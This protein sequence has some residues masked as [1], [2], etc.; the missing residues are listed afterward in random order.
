MPTIFESKK[1]NDS[2]KNP[3][4]FTSFALNPDICFDGQNTDEKVVLM[5]RAHP[6]TQLPWI[7]FSVFLIILPI[8][9]NLFLGRYL[10]FPQTFFLNLFWYSFVLTLAFINFLN[11]LFNVGIITNQRIIDVDYHSVLYKE[12]NATSLSKIEDVT[13]KSSGF[14][15]SI[16]NFGD[17][18][19]QTAGTH[20]N[21]EFANVPNPQRIAGIISETMRKNI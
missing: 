1:D 6:V 2:K 10:T 21:I 14:I 11:Y 19:V 12:V 4:V 3:G 15:N 18:F 8:F 17:I 16:F 7:S 13:A 5:L 9:F 20:E